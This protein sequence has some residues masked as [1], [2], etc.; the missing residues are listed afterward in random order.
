MY[1]TILLLKLNLKM[2]SNHN[3]INYSNNA[4]DLFEKNN[5]KHKHTQPLFSLNIYIFAIA[6]IFKP[7]PKAN[8]S[9]YVSVSF[10]LDF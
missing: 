1:F 4:F 8:M 5:S 3:S 9:L 7:T 10:F 2:C 6:I